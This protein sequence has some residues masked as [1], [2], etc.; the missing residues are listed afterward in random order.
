MAGKPWGGSQQ[1][2]LAEMQTHSS[3]YA[4][5]GYLQEWKRSK[6]KTRIILK[7]YDEVK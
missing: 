2:N 1:W 3:F 5:I 7:I 4:C 6:S